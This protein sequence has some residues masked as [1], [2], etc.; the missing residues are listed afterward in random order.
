MTADA[1]LLG[2]LALL[3]ATLGVVGGLGGAIL[4]VPALV[5]V[6]VAPAEAAP[7]GMLMVAAGSLG[8]AVPQLEE[9]LL[10]HR[11]GVVGE[12]GASLG[13]SVGVLVSG[14]L[15]TTALTW[16]LAGAALAAA[17]ALGLRSGLRNKPDPRT[18]EASIGEHLGRLA[19]AYWLAGAVIP[20]RVRRLSLGLAMLT[21]TGGLAGVTGTSGG[22]LKT[23]ILS[24]VMHVPVKVAAATVTFMVGITAATGLVAYAA[25]G[26]LD[27]GAGM[28]AV[29]GGLVGGRLGA[30]VQVRVSPVIARR[31]LGAV[32]VVVAILLV[33]R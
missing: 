18:D 2:A 20:Y 12:L 24:E 30:L 14:L 10:N 9:G 31:V 5:L 28:V 32:L 3:T 25:Q 19:G 27:V 1:L 15:T 29:V 33:L 23:P 4:F 8:A 17:G 21:L 26:R 16:T 22:Y 11:I 13:V 7:L 6:G